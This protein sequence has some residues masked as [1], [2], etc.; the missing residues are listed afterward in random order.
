LAICVAVIQGWQELAQS[1]IARTAEDN[2]IERLDGNDLRRHWPELQVLLTWNIISL[3]DKSMH[4]WG[5]PKMMASP[6]VKDCCASLAREGFG[7]A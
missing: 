5:G 1:Q 4:G 6:Q 2:Q 3:R 7:L